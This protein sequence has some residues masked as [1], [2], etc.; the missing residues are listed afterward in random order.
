[1]IIFRGKSFLPEMRGW[2][3]LKTTQY[4]YKNISFFF[5]IS[6]LMYVFSN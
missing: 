5:T 4:K 3:Y 2:M 6:F 1:M